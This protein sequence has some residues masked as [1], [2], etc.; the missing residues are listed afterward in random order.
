MTRLAL[1]AVVGLAV[2]VVVGAA[3]SVRAEE[4]PSAETIM[5]AAEAG[6]SAWDL[7]GAA[8]TTGLSSAEYLAHVDEW[9]AVG[10]PPNTDGGLAHGWPIGGALGQR[11]WCVESME[12]G[13]GRWMWNPV[14]LWYG[15]HIEHAAGW[16]GFMPSTARAWGAVIGDRVSEWAAAARMIA[17][18]YGAAFA[19]I[20]WGRC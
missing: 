9:I 4:S 17:A 8:N 3:L 12:S 18:G 19:G 13:H 14:G 10:E 20:A 11:L 16:L 6:I 15:N 2:G 1:G 7:A 5:L